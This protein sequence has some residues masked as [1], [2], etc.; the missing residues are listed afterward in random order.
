M[1]STE[2]APILQTYNFVSCAYLFCICDAVRGTLDYAYQ[3]IDMPPLTGLSFDV[4]LNVY[5]TVQQ[6]KPR[7]MQLYLT[8]MPKKLKKVRLMFIPHSKIMIQR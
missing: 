1:R 5:A 3:S 7:I 4:F 2:G 6:F 8:R